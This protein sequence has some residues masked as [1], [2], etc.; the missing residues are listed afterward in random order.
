MSENNK[1]SLRYIQMK[2][3]KYL[4]LVEPTNKSMR[5][6]QHISKKCREVAQ[7]KHLLKVFQECPRSIQVH[8]MGT[9]S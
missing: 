3:N 5:N 2:A 4:T 8:D 1:C 6:V 7:L 9:A